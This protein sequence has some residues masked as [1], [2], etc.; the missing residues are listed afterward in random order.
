MQDLGE[1]SYILSIKIEHDRRNHTISLSQKQYCKTILKRCGMDDSKPAAMP[2]SSSI[3][4]TA[5]DPED[6]TIIHQMNINGK[7]VSYPSVVGSLM[8]AMLGTRPDLAYTVGNMGCY[9]ASPKKCHWEAAK[10][11]LRYLK[12]TTEIRLVFDGSDLGS[13]D[14]SFH[15]YSD[16]DWSGDPDTSKSTSRFV[17]ISNRLGEQTPNHGG[18]ILHRIGVHWPVLCWSA[19]GIPP[20]TF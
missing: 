5:D 4:L 15:G 3:R 19:L 10:R 8:Y 7:V 14:M 11:A 1:V 9:S 20:N 18:F 6:N 16:A 13:L 17:F 12:G 2:M